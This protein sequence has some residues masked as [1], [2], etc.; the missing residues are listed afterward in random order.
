MAGSL[1]ANYSQEMPLI[2][3]TVTQQPQPEADVISMKSVR[4]QRSAFKPVQRQRSE[5]VAS[6]DHKHGNSPNESNKVMGVTK[7][8]NPVTARPQIE[9]MAPVINSNNSN[10]LSPEEK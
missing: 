6:S 8:I 10:C 1:N 7:M 4:S 2:N 3:V 5:A 9:M